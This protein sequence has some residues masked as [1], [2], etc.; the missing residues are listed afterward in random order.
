M[1]KKMYLLPCLVLTCLMSGVA[2]AEMIAYWP[3]DEGEGT[4]VNDATGNW[5]GEITGD[6]AWVAGYKGSALEFPGGT[7]YVNCGNVQYDDSMSLSYWCLNPTKSFERSIGQ[8]AGNYST[9]P[10]WAVYSRDENEGG[11]WFRVHGA[12][13]AWNGGDIII[14]DNV[15]K[16]EW[17]HLTFTFDGPSRELKGYLN[18]ELKAEKICEAGRAVSPNTKD[19][20]FGHVG[21]GAAYTGSLDEVALFNHVLEEAEIQT[22][23]TKGITLGEAANT[24]VPEDGNPDVPREVTVSW[25]AGIYAATHDVYL[26]TVRDDVTNASVDAPLGTLISQGLDAPVYDAGI[27]DYGQTYYWRVDEVNAAPDNTIFKGETWSFTVEPYSI[28]VESITATASG[29]SAGMDPIKTIDGS[30]LN[31]QDQHLTAPTDM[32]MTITAGSWIQYEFDKAYKLHQLLV[33]NSNQVIESFIGFGVKDATVETSMDGETWT[34]VEGVAPFNRATGLATYQANTT[35]DLSGITAKYVRISP[36][37]AYGMTG[38]SGLSEVRFYY[39]PNTARELQPADGGTT[40]DVEV[41][42]TWRAGREA[43]SHQIYLGTTPDNL[44]L[45]GTTEEAT[46]V[47]DTLDYA[48]TYHWQ[49]VEVNEGETPTTYAGAILQFNTP[50]FGIV[51]NFESYSGK[52]GQEVFMTWLDGYGGDTTLGGSI[53]GHVDGPF[54]ETSNVNSGGK[55][56]P[57]YID[58]DGDFFDIDGKVS[59]PTSSEVLRDLAP[60]Q[61]WTASNIKTLSI[62]FAG[63]PGLT[64]QLYCRIGTTKLLYDGEASNLGVTTWQAWNIDLSTVGANLT[65]VKEFAIGVDGGTSGILYIDDISLYTH[66]GEVITP[67]M[68]DT[69]NLLAHYALDGDYQDASGNGRHGVAVEETNIFFIAGVAGQGM[70]LSSGNGYVEIPGFKGITV[71]DGVQQPFTIANWFKTTETT[72]DQEMVTWGDTPAPQRLTW[73]VHEGRLRTEHGGGNLRGNTYVNDGE[74]HFG[75]LTVAEGANLRPDVTK[76]Y[77][78]GLE[79]SILSGTGSNTAYDLQPV[80]DVCIGCRA[81]NKSR[82][83]IG[84]LDEV[85]IYDRALTASEIAGLAGKTKPIHKPF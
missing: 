26:G 3:M 11:V 82:F 62:M 75:A 33:W 31:E 52:E 74:W 8:H 67:V 47:A 70:D 38:Q 9:E 64:G 40:K 85:R 68:P 66:I 80:S 61:D 19:L 17:Y 14:A 16:T 27:L 51:D 84:A 10:G 57:I 81:D 28:P 71:V 32:W 39:V 56:M 78:D 42:L 35:V 1:Y 23:V 37:S 48:Q 41:A 83:F 20:R 76:L 50:P 46:F 25:N 77:V 30:G 29:S 53:T 59:S 45:V 22:I 43:A 73:R 65:N 60:A 36:E 79:D 24:P 69:A 72:G 12:D 21:T 49:I 13:N 5:P 55:S 18:G 4:A 34:K 7:N 58:N 63:S 44:A 6:V 2:S 15:S 54:V